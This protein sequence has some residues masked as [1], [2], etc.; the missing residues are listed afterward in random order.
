MKIQPYAS[1]IINNY[2]YDRFLA[3]AIAS[4]R[5]NPH[6]KFIVVNDIFT[7]KSRRIVAGYGDRI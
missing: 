6:T 5:N 4:A 2:D 3:E 7:D 1:I